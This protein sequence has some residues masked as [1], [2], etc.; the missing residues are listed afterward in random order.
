[1][2]ETC[3]LPTQAPCIVGVAIPG[4]VSVTAS[5]QIEGAGAA[6]TAGAAVVHLDDAGPAM[7][8]TVLEA[9]SKRCPSVI[10]AVSTGNRGHTLDQRRMVL[11]LRPDMAS[12][13]T[14]SCNAGAGVYENPPGLVRA[15]A[16]EMRGLGVKPCIEVLDLAMLYNAAGLV[17]AGLIDP[18]P[19]VQFVLGVENA[20]PARRDIL[21]FEVRAL[22]QLLPGA[23]WSAAGIG[24]HQRRVAYWALEMGGHCRVALPG[25]AESSG[26]LVSD[27]V[28][29]CAGFG[30]SAATPRQAREILGLAPAVTALA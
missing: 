28:G 10:A 7:L 30:R 15:L 5:G 6:F 17:S 1:M 8:A 4:G 21:D 18:T 24:P 19:H 9:L 11:Q 27:V 23:T 25:D 26:R 14:G 2:A 13:A 16:S 12:L 20:L 3:F 29:I 22:G